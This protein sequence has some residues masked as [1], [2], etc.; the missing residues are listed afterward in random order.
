MQV[1]TT[2]VRY[3]LTLAAGGLL[4]QGTVIA[5]VALAALV[6]VGWSVAQ[7]LRAERMP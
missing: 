3:A 5:A 1:I 7:R 6:V 4:A 2:L